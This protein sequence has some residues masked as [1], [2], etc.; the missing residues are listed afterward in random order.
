MKNIFL[1]LIILMSCISCKK[2]YT[3][4]CYSDRRG[5]I[6]LEQTYS[7]KEQNKSKALSKCNSD[8]Q[9]SSGYVDGYCEIK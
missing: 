3:C 4:Q 1:I 8:Y 9:N 7:Y 5:F 2:N 6:F